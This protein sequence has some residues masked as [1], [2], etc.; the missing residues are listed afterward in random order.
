MRKGLFSSEKISSLFYFF[1]LFFDIFRIKF[2]TLLRARGR[3]LKMEKEKFQP[4]TSVDRLVFGSID[5]FR[6]KIQVE[7]TLGE[8]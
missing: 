7:K 8:I 1:V 3:S 5:D 6:N 2:A 4:K